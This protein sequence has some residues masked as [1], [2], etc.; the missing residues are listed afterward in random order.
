MGAGLRGVTRLRIAK[1]RPGQLRAHGLPST[2]GLRWIGDFILNTDDAVEPAYMRPP[3]EVA[4]ASDDWR[5]TDVMRKVCEAMTKANWPPT[6]N[7]VLDRVGG[8]NKIVRRALAVIIDEHYI[9]LQPV[10][11]RSKLHTLIKPYREDNGY[12]RASLVRPGRTRLCGGR[13][14]AASPSLIG[15]RTPHRHARPR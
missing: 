6:Q 8:R 15:T 7:G 13:V 11:N 1:D 3:A 2:T 10:P 12:V 14:C 4:K 5:A 9:D